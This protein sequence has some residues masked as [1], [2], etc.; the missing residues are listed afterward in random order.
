MICKKN[1]IPKNMEKKIFANATISGV[2]KYC[3]YTSTPVFWFS[4]S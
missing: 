4:F 3:I 2:S 1:G